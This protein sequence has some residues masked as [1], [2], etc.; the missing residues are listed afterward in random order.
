MLKHIDNIEKVIRSL[1]NDP[2]IKCT[3]R[4]ERFTTDIIIFD[5]LSRCYFVL[6]RSSDIDAYYFDI[7]SFYKDA[8]GGFINQ[9][10]ACR[11]ELYR[12]I[13]ELYR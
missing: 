4:R 9:A 1:T 8:I 7:G 2:Y 13:H 12:T 5:E 10:I 6:Y 11:S 3:Y